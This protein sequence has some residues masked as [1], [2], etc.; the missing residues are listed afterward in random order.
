M[1]AAEIIANVIAWLICA[2]MLSV[3]HVL[4]WRIWV[5]RPHRTMNGQDKWQRSSEIQAERGWPT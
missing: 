2:A 5:K 1:T 4:V 3:C